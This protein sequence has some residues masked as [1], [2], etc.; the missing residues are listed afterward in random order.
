[1]GHQHQP[2]QRIARHG[3]DVVIPGRA[4]S[5]RAQALALDKDH[6]LAPRILAR[7]AGPGLRVRERLQEH[8]L[9]LVVRRR[10][11]D[12]ERAVGES[13]AERGDEFLGVALVGRVPRLA[14]VALRAAADRVEQ[15]RHPLVHG[16]VRR[17]L[18]AEQP[19]LDTA[20]HGRSPAGLLTSRG[21]IRSSIEAP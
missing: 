3:E 13:R 8:L 7:A 17:A 18:A 1:V 9:R 20:A 11:A 19:P 16:A 2:L 21:S 5:E 14:V 10:P 6:G 15:L 12:L 4:P